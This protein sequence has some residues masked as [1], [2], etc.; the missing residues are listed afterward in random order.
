MLFL[1]GAPCK[2]G[3]VLLPDEVS[4]VLPQT[5][6][7]RLIRMANV[8]LQRVQE[9]SQVLWHLTSQGQTPSQESFSVF[10]AVEP[11]NPKQ[12]VSERFRIFNTAHAVYIYGDDEHGLI[13]GIGKFLRLLSAGWNQSYT[14]GLQRY[15]CMPSQILID[16]KPQY[17]IRGH[18]IAYRALSD[19]YG[20]WSF[21]QMERYIEDLVIFG[22]N[23]IECVFLDGNPSPQFVV[24]P[25]DMIVHMSRVSESFGLNFSIWYPSGSIQYDPSYD[26]I[27]KIPRINSIFVPGGDPGSLSP[28]PLFQLIKN[29]AINVRK[30]HPHAQVRFILLKSLND[31]S[32][33]SDFARSFG[34]QLKALTPLK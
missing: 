2:N 11:V 7:V 4:I 23:T 29:I 9:K 3:Q 26:F 16:T 8:L 28:A 14:S 30:Y 19:S 6:S 12:I 18:Q 22:T 10:L 32:L 24:P 21:A 13:F 1:I 27:R 34:S 20:G 31:C 5:P 33:T 25:K 15:V 17:S